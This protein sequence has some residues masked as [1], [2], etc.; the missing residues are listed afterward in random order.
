[1]EKIC[2]FPHGFDQMIQEGNEKHI[3]KLQVEKKIETSMEGTQTDFVYGQ[4][5]VDHNPNSFIEVLPKDFSPS[6][7]DFDIYASDLVNNKP[8]TLISIV[9]IRK[10]LSADTS[11][12]V[13]L[14]IQSGILPIIIKLMKSNIPQIQYECAWIITNCASGN[15][16][17]VEHLINLNAHE[18]FIELLKSSSKLLVEQAI[19]GLGNLAGDSIKIRN[20]LLDR[21]ILPILIAIVEK[22]D[23][24]SSFYA[25][26]IWTIS[27]MCRGRPAPKIQ[28]VKFA[29]PLLI[30]SLETSKN[31]EIIS[32]SAWTFPYLTEDSSLGVETIMEAGFMDCATKL[33]KE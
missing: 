18:A 26:G 14:A 1:L 11:P 2:T 24:E 25:Y 32:D 28:L 3:P 30:K 12:P 19:W 20:M 29:I 9:G 5:L 17:E 16:E 4:G 15:N 13:Q 31:E 33:I 27:N 22:A 7:E 8:N 23:P 6:K 10:F 21:G